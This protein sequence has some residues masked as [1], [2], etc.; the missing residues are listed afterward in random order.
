MEY[1]TEW[2]DQHAQAWRELVHYNPPKS[3]LEIGIYEGASMAW[4]SE[5]SPQTR[6]ITGI[7]PWIS[8]NEHANTDMTQ[9]ERRFKQNLQELKTKWPSKTYNIHKQPS[10]IALTQLMA[11]S[12]QFDW[13]YID[14]NHMSDAVLLDI[15][16]S[17]RLLNTDGMMILDDYAWPTTDTDPRHCPRLAIDAFLQIHTDYTIW[18]QTGYQMILQKKIK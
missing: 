4:I 17:W 9:I 6:Y 10:L 3:Y 13:I 15:T 12:Q 16:L 11:R 18:P 7:D 1:T 8:D 14:G 2:H 5:H